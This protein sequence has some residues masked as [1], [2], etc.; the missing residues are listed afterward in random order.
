VATETTKMLKSSFE[1][2]LSHTRT[3]EWSAL[4]EKNRTAIMDDQLLRSLSLK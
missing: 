4:F 1:E 2:T 3:F